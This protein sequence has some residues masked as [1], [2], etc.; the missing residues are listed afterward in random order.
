MLICRYGNNGIK[1]VAYK[2]YA[3]SA[4]RGR[5]V[6]HRG[7]Q[8]WGGGVEEDPSSTN[9]LVHLAYTGINILCSTISH[10][11]WRQLIFFQM[12]RKADG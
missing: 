9:E 8:G 12:S 1:D 3:S 7:R 5:K 6:G 4:Q 2:C 10:H 11:L